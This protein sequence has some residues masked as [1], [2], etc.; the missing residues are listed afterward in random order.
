MTQTGTVGTGEYVDMGEY[1]SPIPENMITKVR[2]QK[3]RCKC[4]EIKE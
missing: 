1:L 2:V 3:Y 4:E